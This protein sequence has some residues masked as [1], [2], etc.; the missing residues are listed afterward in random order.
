MSPPFNWFFALIL[1]IGMAFG[2]NAH[3][4][5]YGY[6]IPTLFFWDLF[7][8]WQFPFFSRFCE[9]QV[10]AGGAAFELAG[11]PPVTPRGWPSL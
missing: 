9:G 4:P 7:F 5:G 6:L 1:V 8:S 3:S 10:G 2:M 11:R